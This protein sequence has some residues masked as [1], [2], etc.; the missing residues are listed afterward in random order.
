MPF[1]KTDLGQIYTP[2]V[3][4]EQMMQPPQW[5]DFGGDEQPIDLA[6]A[7]QAFKQ[8]FMQKPQGA[9]PALP[10]EMGHADLNPTSMS[11]PKS[12]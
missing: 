5:V 6:P 1:N 10:H 11:K 3:M 12:L 9:S 2:N 8:R 7:G 4:P